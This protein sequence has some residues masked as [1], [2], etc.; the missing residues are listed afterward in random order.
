MRYFVLAPTGER[1]GPADVATLNEW[2]ASNRLSPDSKL[3]EEMS[4]TVT[5]ASAIPGLVFP[6]ASPPTPMGG[7]MQPPPPGTPYQQPSNYPRP[8]YGPNPPGTGFV[9]P[10]SGF[11]GRATP[12]KNDLLLSFGMVLLSPLLSLFCIYGFTAALIGIG[13]GWR[14][15]QGGQKIALLAV[16]LNGCALVFWAFARFVFRHWLLSGIEPRYR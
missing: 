9:A 12:N 6:Q 1:Y 11:M 10:G 2:A 3:M 8:G 15:F 14:A 16:I 4:G 5:P 7:P 13:A